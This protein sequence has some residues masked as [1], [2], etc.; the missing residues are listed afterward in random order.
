MEARNAVVKHLIT[1]K[2]KCVAKEKFMKAKGENVVGRSLTT[3]RR[4]DVVKTKM[5]MIDQAS[6]VAGVRFYNV[7]AIQ[8]AAGINLTTVTPNTA[9]TVE[10]MTKRMT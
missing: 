10:F 5:S 2:A 4:S 6:L 3:R 8:A 1:R 7:T 9:A